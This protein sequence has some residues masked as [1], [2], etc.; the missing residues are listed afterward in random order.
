MSPT[1]RVGALMLAALVVLG[2][3]VIKIE[4][5]PIGAKAGRH[6][7]EVLFPSVAGLD[8]KSPVRIAGV[9]VGIVES[10]DLDGQKALVTLGLDSEVQLHQGAWA[11]VSSMGMLGDKYISLHP[12]APDQPA[13]AA[14]TVLQGTSPAGFDDVLNT[15]E[16]IGGDIKQVTA[17]LRGSLGGQQG[18]QRIDD[19]LENIRQLTAEMRNLVAANRGQIDATLAN[20]RDFSETLKRELPRLADKL[21]ALADDVDGVVAEN[22]AG[23]QDSVDN[24]KEL[25]AR[26]RVTADNLNTITGKIAAGEGTIGKLVAED[27]TATNLNNTLKAVE[28]GA[29]AL[30]ETLGRAKSYGL[31]LTMRGESLPGIDDYRAAFGFDLT[32]T[33]KKFYR[34]EMVNTPVGREQTLTSTVTRR[35]SDGTTE[36][37]VEEKTKVTDQTTF[38]A[39]I[40]YHLFPE[41]TVRGGLIESRA[42]FGIDQSLFRKK[43]VLSLE[44]YDFGRDQNPP[45]LRFEGRYFL[46]DNIFAY[47]GWDDPTWSE[48]SSVLFGG[49]I[50]WSD[51][52]L[53]YLLGTAASASGG[54]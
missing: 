31:D 47:A 30:Q 11:E 45:H 52:D 37:Y 14:G 15:V 39:Q 29:D 17:S 2:V 38:N 20:F 40:G 34:V 26:L 9:R 44:A 50:T 43:V 23:I 49:G 35:Y 41:L 1:A 4:E 21:T 48:G 22:R 18:E 46:T 33:G 53:K 7:V 12:G 27:E 16:D 25:T 32:T 24:V 19:I 5:I 28:G 42:G 36:S 8:E 13:L 3:F 54:L 10:I 51:D 6:R